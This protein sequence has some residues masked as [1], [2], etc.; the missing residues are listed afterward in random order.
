MEKIELTE[1]QISVAKCAERKNFR[2]HGVYS[3]RGT[4]PVL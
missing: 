3:A 4:E 1:E 2:D